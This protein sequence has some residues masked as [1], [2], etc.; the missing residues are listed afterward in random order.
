MAPIGSVGRDGCDSAAAE[1]VAPPTE[2]F[3]PNIVSAS[4]PR[5]RR[6]GAFF[7]NI[8]ADQLHFRCGKMQIIGS[9]A[10]GDVE[11]VIEQPAIVWD[12]LVEA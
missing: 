5:L 6:G 12:R 8:V 3:A 11:G 10:V 4:G 1:A 2:D 9:L 7:R